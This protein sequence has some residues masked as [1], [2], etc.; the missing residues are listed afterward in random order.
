MSKRNFLKHLQTVNINSPLTTRSGKIRKIASDD[1][2]IPNLSRNIL[3]RSESVD[4]IFNEINEN[5]QTLIFN[6]RQL[7]ETF[8]IETEESVEDTCNTE[9]NRDEVFE[10]ADDGLDETIYNPCDDF[11]FVDVEYDEIDRNSKLLL[12][13]T[14][15]N[16]PKLCDF[17]Y[18]YTIEKKIGNNIIWRCERTGNKSRIKCNGRASTR[19]FNLPIEDSNEHNHEPD[20][21]QEEVYFYVAKILN[22]AKTTSEDPRSIIKLCLVGISQ[23]ASKKMPRANALTQRIVRIRQKKV[24]YG[25]NPDSLQDIDL[26]A[27]LRKSLR[28]ENFFH[29]DSGQDDPSRILVFATD[30]NIHLINTNLDWYGDGT[31]DVSPLLFKQ[32]FSI[33]AAINGKVIPL[34]CAILPDKKETTYDKLFSMIKVYLNSPV[35]FSC[36]FEMAILN[37]LQRV[38][39][40]CQ[41]LGCWFHLC[42][43]LWRH[44]QEYKLSKK[45]NYKLSVY[46]SFQRLKCLP[47]VP[48]NDVPKA[49][50]LIKAES[51]V[52]FKPMIIY[53]ETYYIG[54]LKKNSKSVRESPMFKHDLWNVFDRVAKDLPRTNNNLET[55]HKNFENS[56]KKHPTVNSLVHQFRLE[57]NFNDVIIDQLESGL[58][59]YFKNSE[60]RIDCINY[61]LIFKG[62]QKASTTVQAFKFMR[63]QEFFKKIE[64]KNIVIWC[65]T[66]PHFRCSEVVDFFFNQLAKEY[67]SV[68]LN[69]FGDKHGKNTRDQ[70]FSVVSNYIKKESLEKKLTC[71]QDIVDALKRRQKVSNDL[72]KLSAKKKGKKLN[73]IN[74]IAQKF[75]LT[76]ETISNN[77]QIIKNIRCYYNFK[78]IEPKFDLMSSIFS[79]DDSQFKYKVFSR[80]ST[81]LKNGPCTSKS[82]KSPFYTSSDDSSDEKASPFLE[83]VSAKLVSTNQELLYFQN[84]EKTVIAEIEFLKNELKLSE[85]NL[86]SIISLSDSTVS[87]VNCLERS[88]KGLCDSFNYMKNSLTEYSFS[89]SSSLSQSSF[90]RNEDPAEE[91]A[92]R[93]NCRIACL[94]CPG[95][96]CKNVSGFNLHFGKKHKEKSFNDRKKY[97]IQVLGI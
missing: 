30:R 78:A 43:N 79:N 44:M 41:I 16:K 89:K 21:I 73:P 84:R 80:Y 88:L 97:S 82:C 14:Q 85:K 46:K 71:S 67:S 15:Q 37:S 93:L 12:V 36:D 58:G 91:E 52:Q 72:R 5:D 18:F 56:C 28:K 17:G 83:Y 47:F 6:D 27:E 68:Y 2:E 25:P 70:H 86:N 48:Q 24:D 63:K 57:Q 49:F 62:S 61:D 23:E 38:F 95:K 59:I 1:S 81:P 32:I 40:S 39:P 92:T 35:S 76:D 33:Q 31:F 77:F 53:F 22:R 69:F 34:L 75:E 54:N 8:V 65:D 19:N 10:A 26:S 94:L 64:K 20:L 51:P 13:P 11:H 4:A 9:E 74:L 50:E 66:G 42:Q 3:T 90:L 87:R 55:W 60:G 45:E 29:D 96:I 7:D